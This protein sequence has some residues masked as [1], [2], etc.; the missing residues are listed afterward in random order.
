MYQNYFIPKTGHTEP[1]RDTSLLTAK[2][3]S[4]R[5]FHKIHPKIEF[6]VQSYKFLNNRKISDI[7]SIFTA[8]SW[9]IKFKLDT[10]NLLQLLTE[11]Y[12]Y[13][14]CLWRKIESPE[15]HGTTHTTHCMHRK[16]PDVQWKNR[17]I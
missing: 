8:C 10:C 1:S 2:T 5:D 14:F 16:V 15:L 11:V 13:N 9:L 3:L 17:S 12:N 7:P 6:W 4:S